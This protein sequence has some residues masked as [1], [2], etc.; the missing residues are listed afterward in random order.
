MKIL[1]GMSCSDTIVSG[2]FKHICQVGEKFRQDGVEAVYAT[3]GNGKVIEKAA[4][5][6]A[7]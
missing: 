6:K 4:G 5:K 2:T 7:K 3:G 1:T